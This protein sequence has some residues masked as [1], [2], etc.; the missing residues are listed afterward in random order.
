M[1]QKKKPKDLALYAFIMLPSAFAGIP[2]Y[3]FL[4]DYYHQAF[5]VSLLIIS[6]ILF[7]LRIFDAIV[8]PVIG[9]YCDHY[10][11]Y[12]Y[13]SL[14]FILV[15]FMFGFYLALNPVA[16]FYVASLFIGVLLFSIAFSFINILT[17]AYGALWSKQ[18]KHKATIISYREFFS[19]IGVLVG[20]LLPFFLRQ[21]TQSANS[22]RILSII[23]ITLIFLGGIMFAIWL[24]N[25]GDPMLK[26]KF[27]DKRP[28]LLRHYVRG[29]D[30]KGLRFYLIYFVSAL[31]SSIPAVMLVF[32]SRLVLKTPEQTGLYLFYYFIGTLLAIPLYKKL[33]SHFLLMR[34]WA[35]TICITI[36]IFIFSL[37]LQPGDSIAFMLISFL[38]GICF[39]GEIIIPNIWLAQWID[40]DHR[41]HLGHG[42][43][44]FMAFLAKLS[45]ALATIMSLP[46]I[47]R[48]NS[49]W[50]I[51]G[52]YCLL[53]CVIK[54]FA[55]VLILFSKTAK[56]NV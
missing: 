4:P 13:V 18:L 39:A 23:F 52:L 26:R 33:V 51:K 2:I 32:F 17:Y 29:L 55:V 5:G 43:Y 37:L 10:I 42:Y 28:H 12:R 44:S 40:Q 49:P 9:W 19:L 47:D 8:D 25:F 24:K 38:S 36:V 50:V 22:N 54:G 35:T 56:T 16:P 21:S 7:I 48:F 14:F 46:W 31:G 3:I 27:K 15:I 20:T 30:L 11:R 34:L 53:P 41:Q 1:E 6:F 45:F